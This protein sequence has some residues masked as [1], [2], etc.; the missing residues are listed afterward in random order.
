MPLINADRVDEIF[1]DCLFNKG[2]NTN[3]SIKAEG[4]LVDVEFHPE[5][6]ESYRDEVKQMLD[7]LP[8]GFHE[9]TGGGWTFPQACNDRNGDQWTDFQQRMEQ[10][11]QLGIGLGLAKY[12][13]PKD[14]WS[15]IPGGMPYIVVLDKE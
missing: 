9:K 12:R 10:L 2:E 5:R 4:I 1:R 11:F 13:L 6:L 3:N 15:T 14:K 7:N 8:A